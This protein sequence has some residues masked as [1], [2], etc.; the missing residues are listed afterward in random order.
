VGLHIIHPKFHQQHD[1]RH[2]EGIFLEGTGTKY[3]QQMQWII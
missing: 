3:K 1:N 2:E